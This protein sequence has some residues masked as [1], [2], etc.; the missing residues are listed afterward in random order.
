MGAMAATGGPERGPLS[1][2][3]PMWI[4]R[5][6]LRQPYTVAVMSFVILL[7]GWLAT[8]AMPVDIFPVIDIPVVAVF[9]NYNGFSAQDFTASL[10]EVEPPLSLERRAGN[11]LQGFPLNRCQK[12]RT[13]RIRPNPIPSRIR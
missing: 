1:P 7:M 2:A 10:V 9:W 13:L 5:L 11:H 4:V 3:P 12:P 8:R 6:A